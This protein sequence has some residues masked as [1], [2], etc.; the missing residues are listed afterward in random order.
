MLMR[1]PIAA[2][3]LAVV[4][5]GGSTMLLGCEREGPAERFGEKVDETQEKL[6]DKLN[7]DGPAE[8]AGKK[9]DKAVDDVTD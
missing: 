5:A 8:K 6:K 9:L 4:L 1:R 2:V 3:V 7:P